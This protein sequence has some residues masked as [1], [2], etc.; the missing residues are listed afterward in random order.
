MP[1]WITVADMEDRLR[2]AP[3]EDLLDGLEVDDILGPVPA[4]RP[5]VRQYASAARRSLSA[6]L[7]RERILPPSTPKPPNEPAVGHPQ[8]DQHDHMSLSDDDDEPICRVCLTGDAPMED[9]GEGGVLGALIQPCLCSGSVAWIHVG[10]LSRWRRSSSSSTAAASCPQCGLRYRFSPPRGG[11]P[12][13]WAIHCQP[14][15]LLAAAILVIML[16]C[17]TGLMAMTTIQYLGK[18]SPTASLLQT[19]TSPPHPTWRIDLGTNQ[20]LI[21][22]THYGTGRTGDS[23]NWRRE[24]VDSLARSSLEAIR[25]VLE[26]KRTDP[27]WVDLPWATAEHQIPAGQEPPAEKKE[28][29]VVARTWSF[30]PLQLLLYALSSTPRANEKP[31]PPGVSEALDSDDMDSDFWDLPLFLITE[32]DAEDDLN[33]WGAELQPARASA[34]LDIDRLI[35]ASAAPDP[36]SLDPKV[37]S[38]DAQRE[39]LPHLRQVT[40]R[41]I[42]TAAFEGASEGERL[43][44]RYTPSSRRPSRAARTIGFSYFIKKLFH[45]TMTCFNAVFVSMN[46]I[47]QIMHIICAEGGR[48]FLDGL[49]RSGAGMLVM[50]DARHLQWD[51]MFLLARIATLALVALLRQHYQA[52]APLPR[53]LPGYPVPIRSRQRVVAGW[54]LQVVLAAGTAL[55][56]PYW[57]DWWGGYPLAAYGRPGVAQ[58]L[59]FT[60]TLA[61]SPGLPIIADSLLAP[62]ATASKSVAR[63]RAATTSRWTMA[64][65]TVP[66]DTAAERT[67]R[68]VRA[69]IDANEPQAQRSPLDVYRALTQSDELR[70]G[71]VRPWDA[72]SLVTKRTEA[73]L[74][75]LVRLQ[76]AITLGA[77]IV[78]AMAMLYTMIVLTHSHLWIFWNQ[79][80][81]SGRRIFFEGIRSLVTRLGRRLKHWLPSPLRCWGGCLPIRTAEAAGEDQGRQAQNVEGD[82]V[83]RRHAHL[84][85]RLGNFDLGVRI[86]PFRQDDMLEDDLGRDDVLGNDLLRDDEINEAMPVDPGRGDGGLELDWMNRLALQADALAEHQGRAVEVD[87]IAEPGPP[88]AAAAAARAAGEAAAA[89][90]VQIRPARNNNPRPARAAEFLTDFANLYGSLEIILNHLRVAAVLGPFLPLGIFYARL[91]MIETRYLL[92]G[93]VL[94]LSARRNRA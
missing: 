51:G 55:L 63:V 70:I 9:D 65:W 27:V 58:E 81:L 26:R 4:F 8:G 50:F 21:T 78:V 92:E 16:A 25:L 56:G 30:S 31:K 1:S 42:Y 48:A 5:A 38:G 69:L 85:V 46:V 13:V 32:E 35:E 2:E 87:G 43:T 77:P 90:G 91:R 57:A 94:D 83:E 15:R 49:S 20:P 68:L 72:I 89:A 75:L 33:F 39:T 64:P 29:A 59:F 14:L 73:P 7:E 12:A 36:I 23:L 82:A 10:C 79:I 11:P 54:T 40:I 18:W 60:Q 84:H 66:D 24:P 52:A 28:Y 80:A 37:R 74:P 53:I 93:K 6:E 62:L 61:G 22:V 47:L 19:L 67:R 17:S 41:H 45:A 88:R 86:V 44:E 3:E 71:H 34:D 76:A